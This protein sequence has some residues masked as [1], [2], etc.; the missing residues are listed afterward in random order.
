MNSGGSS[1]STIF[2]LPPAYRPTGFVDVPVAIVGG[3]PGVLTI[4]LDGTVA[5]LSGSTTFV[6][7]EGVTFRPGN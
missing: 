5:P 2:K 3:E 1:N 4:D 7:L 6:D